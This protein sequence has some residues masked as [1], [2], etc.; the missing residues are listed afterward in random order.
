MTILNRGVI[1]T[2][3]KDTEKISRLSN[4]MS[5]LTS[6]LHIRAYK[7]GKFRTK[8]NPA[9]KRGLKYYY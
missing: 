1:T 2:E 6:H 3:I 9:Q 5:G 8:K 7:L 4:L